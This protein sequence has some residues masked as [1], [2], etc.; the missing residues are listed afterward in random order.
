MPVLY[1]GCLS[2]PKPD[3]FLTTIIEPVLCHLTEIPFSKEA[4]MLLL[5]PLSKKAK[6]LNIGDK[7]SV[8]RLAT[9]R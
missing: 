3:N 4:S 8:L 5:A 6:T 1:Q 7:L 9:F 2:A